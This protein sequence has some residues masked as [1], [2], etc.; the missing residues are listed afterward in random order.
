MIRQW[1]LEVVFSHVTMNKTNLN[2][3]GLTIPPLNLNL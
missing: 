3:L 2:G 1:P